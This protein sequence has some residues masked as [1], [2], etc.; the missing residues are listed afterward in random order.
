MEFESFKTLFE[1]LDKNEAKALQEQCKLIQRAKNSVL[2][3][4]GEICD[5]IL[6]LCEG[7]VSICI[8]TDESELFLYDFCQNELCIVNITSALSQSEALASAYAKTDIKGFLIPK[9]LFGDLLIKIPSFQK[10]FFASFAL[11]YASLI[12]LIE[13]IKF[14]R[15]DSRILDLLHSF[16]KKEIPITNAQIAETLNSSKNVVNR[17]LQDLK[18]RGKLELKRGL[19]ILK[20]DF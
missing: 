15:L 9:Q 4:E 8:S 3:Y 10:K 7:K 12:T 19:I 11:R 18:A 20:G 16:N 1:E 2:F 13:D 6:F 5:E 17:I 14:K